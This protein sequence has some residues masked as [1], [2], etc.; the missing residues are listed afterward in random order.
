ML[1]LCSSFQILKHIFQM[2]LQYYRIVGWLY[3]IVSIDWLVKQHTYK[4]KIL[5]FNDIL[6]MSQIINII[7]YLFSGSAVPIRKIRKI[8]LRMVKWHKNIL[9]IRDSFPFSFFCHSRA[10]DFYRILCCISKLCYFF[11]QNLN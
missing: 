8:R 10:R 4:Y 7:D 1:L 11:K 6:K 5:C 3:K 2:L 9:Q